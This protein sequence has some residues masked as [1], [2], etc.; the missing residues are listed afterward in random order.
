MRRAR[1]AP[2]MISTPGHRA[3]R[4][5][6]REALPAWR[7]SRL[8]MP[9]IK[10]VYDAA[11]GSMHISPCDR[12]AGCNTRSRPSKQRMVMRFEKLT[13]ARDRKFESISL[14]QAVRLSREVAPRG[15]EPRLFAGVCGPWEVV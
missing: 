4:R 15:R 2:A 12:G 5:R 10:P 7:E 6:Q 9:P 3:A 8:D 14:Q 11:F 1:L 13:A